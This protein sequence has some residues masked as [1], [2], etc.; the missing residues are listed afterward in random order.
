M[1]KLFGAIIGALAGIVLASSALVVHD[2]YAL[3]QTISVP[4]IGPG[5]L[6]ATVDR[7]Q[8]LLNG[9]PAGPGSQYVSPAQVLG[10][11]KYA[12]YTAGLANGGGYN[13]YFGQ[14]QQYIQLNFAGTESYSYLTLE[15]LPSD[16]ARECVFTTGAITSVYLAAYSASQTVNSGITTLAAN[17]GACYLYSASNTTWDR[18]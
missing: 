10:T 2:Q 7:L 5:L 18:D 13:W 8:Y 6:N 14:D 4:Q 16:G 12:K 3:G 11:S 15:P 17:T 9:Y 1:K